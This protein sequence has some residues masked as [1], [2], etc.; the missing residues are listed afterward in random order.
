MKYDLDREIMTEF[1]AL[2]PR[3]YSY[4]ADDNNKNKKAKGTKMC[5]KMK[6]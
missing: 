3:T 1:S 4:L 2:R 5:D 6:T